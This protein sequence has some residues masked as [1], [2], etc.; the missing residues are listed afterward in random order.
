[1]LKAYGSTINITWWDTEQSQRR[2]KECSL[3][4]EKG[5]VS[6]KPP[7][8]SLWLWHMCL[9][10]LTCPVL[11]I[12]S[13]VSLT[14]CNTPTS[15]ILLKASTSTMLDWGSG[16]K[17]WPRTSGEHPPKCKDA[18][19]QTVKRLL[20]LTFQNYAQN[21]TDVNKQEQRSE[22]IHRVL[23]KMRTVCFQDLKL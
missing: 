7:S 20:T 5:P 18:G 16:D 8:G 22:K 17:S 6:S 12:L 15:N 2:A 11:T 13:S 3:S 19:K 9:V 10:G 4:S 14:L 21:W 1:M 23:S